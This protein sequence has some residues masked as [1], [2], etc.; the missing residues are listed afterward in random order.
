M[1]I[2][3]ACGIK[4]DHNRNF[5]TDC[6][7]VVDTLEMNIAPSAMPSTK[8][9]KPPRRPTNAWEKGT[10]KDE[11]GVAYLDKQ[12]KPLKNGEGFNQHDYKPKPISISAN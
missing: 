3:Q 2:C 1:R 7:S 5:C 6:N 9:N 12:G 10:R 8:N 4:Q 11:R